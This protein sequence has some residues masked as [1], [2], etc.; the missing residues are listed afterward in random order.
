MSTFYFLCVRCDTKWF[1]S[2]GS[3]ECPRCGL[4][5]ETNQ[6]YEMP[7]LTRRYDNA[8]KRGTAQQS[9]AKRQNI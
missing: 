8:C 6:Q 3:C 9:E 1:A 7:W 4:R 2:R 5:S